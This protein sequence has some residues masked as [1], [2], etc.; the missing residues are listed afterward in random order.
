MENGNEQ[1]YTIFWLHMFFLYIADNVFC[2]V[3]DPSCYEKNKT[4]DINFETCQIVHGSRVQA[5]LAIISKILVYL[6][7]YC[8]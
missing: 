8:L 4:F 6:T 1:N 7:V 2:Y 5:K 3:F